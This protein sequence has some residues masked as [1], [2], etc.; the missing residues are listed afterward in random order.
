MK[1]LKK[2]LFSSVIIFIFGSCQKDDICP[3][4]TATT[5]LLGIIFNDVAELDRL[6]AVPGLSVRATGKEE[7]FLAPATVNE[8]AIPLRTDEN[9]TEY[10]FTR[11]AGSE[12]ENQD[13][14]TFTY[15]PNL[16]Y[17]NRACGYKVEFLNLVVNIHEDEDNWINADIILQENVENETEAH[18]SFTH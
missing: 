17:L 9:F 14:V 11:N 12:D 1:H 7:N 15:S 2:F 18:L 3:P 13:V 6:K 4:N 5:P 8:I 16:V 10:I